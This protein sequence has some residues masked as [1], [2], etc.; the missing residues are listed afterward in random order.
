VSSQHPWFLD[1]LN[2]PASP[3]RDWFIWSE[4]NPGYVGPWGEQVWDR[5]PSRPEYYYAIFYEGM[6]DLNYRNPAVTEEAYK[7]S[8][9]WLNEMGVDGFRLDAIKHVIENGKEQE[10]TRETH[11]WLRDYAVF[12]RSTKP[13]VFTVGEVFDGRLDVLGGY[14]PDQLDTFFEFGVS[15]ALL[16]AARSGDGQALTAAVTRAV[17]Q[18]PFQRWAPFLTNH[19]QTRTMTVHGGSQGRARVAAAALLTVPGL[20]CVYY[21]EE[22]G[23]TGDKPD[24]RL[25]TPMQWSAEP[26]GGFSTVQPWEPLQ[27]GAEL[28]NVAA[29]DADPQSLLYQYRR[30][31]H[32]HTSTPA[33]A[34]G[35]FTPLVLSG[36]PNV[37]AFVRRSGDSAVLVLL[38][39]GEQPIDAMDLAAPASDLA[40]GQYQLRSLLG[41][42]PAGQI[43]ISD[44]GAIV[45]GNVP[46]VPALS[47]A[48]FAIEP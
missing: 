5:S 16:D 21:G 22:I 4:R 47:G 42:L 48:V 18:L 37:S 19:D 8:A 33:L 11:A 7:I 27:S 30:L 6:P 23:L 13:D 38:N 29:Q 32:L 34:Q 36:R 28:T 14:Y 2:N 24:E 1:A 25:R 44:E 46:G 15:A 12:L 35:S 9:F 31:I 3:Y 20:P 26:A 43:S 45:S 40:P 39:F 41:E 10:N 17:T